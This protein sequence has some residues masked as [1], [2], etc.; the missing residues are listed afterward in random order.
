MSVANA[1][2]PLTVSSVNPRYFT[3][4]S[5]E[6]ANR[7]LI[8]LT[9]SHCHNNF[10]T[11]LGPGR[12]CPP[13][14]PEQFDFRD[15]SRLPHPARSQLHSTVALGTVPGLPFTG[16]GPFLHEAAT[17][18]ADGTRIRQGRQAEV[19]SVRLR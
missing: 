8:Y 5:I 4:D 16:R 12:E 19:Q 13:E 7:K 9:G 17:V 14:D 1:P 11:G 6:A 15:L 3:V 10:H 2:G 18:A